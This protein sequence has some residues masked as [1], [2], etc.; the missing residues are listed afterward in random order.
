MTTLDTLPLVRAIMGSK[1]KS[2]LLTY[3]SGWDRW[4]G[5][6]RA[7]DRPV[8]PPNAADLGLSM[9]S[10]IQEGLSESVSNNLYSAVLAFSSTL[11]DLDLS[12]NDL[13][14]DVRKY[15]KKIAVKKHLERDPL[16][17]EDLNKIYENTDWSD[18]LSIRNTVMCVVAWHGF[19][20]Y[21]DLSVIRM[22]DIDMQCDHF[23]LFIAKSKTDPAG[24]G[25]RVIVA[26]N[27]S[28]MDPWFLLK[29][30]I[31]EVKSGPDL[32]FS[33]LFSEM[34]LGNGEVLM[35]DFTAI[36]YKTVNGIV[37]QLAKD[38]NLNMTNVGSHCLRVGGAT[39][40]TQRGVSS[41]VVMAKG[42][43]RCESTRLRYARI[44][45]QNI[46]ETS[47]IFR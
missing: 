29:W 42:R 38:L 5:W 21:S 16:M 3:A 11:G 1:E 37:K 40:Y 43:W 45:K 9:L 28:K 25:Q 8:W 46:V 7:V 20:R 27:F 35:E 47:D 13:L 41:E 17:Y 19:L 33:Y 32:K 26:R 4:R 10:A 31:Q 36:H 18:Y 24:E 39:E 2:S 22:T 15:I 12:G 14:G 30:F 44:T 6:C 34:K 23:S